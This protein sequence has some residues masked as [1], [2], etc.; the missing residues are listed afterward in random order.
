MTNGGPARERASPYA[1]A[2]WI[3]VATGVILLS[4]GRVPICTCGTIKLWH[5]AVNS[6]ENSQHLTDWYTFSHIIHGFIFYA[7]LWWLKPEWS[8]AERFLA[9]M[10][11]ESGWEILENSP[12]I[13]NRYRTA[14]ISLDYYGDSVINSLSDIAAMAAGFT[15]ASVLPVAATVA[16]ALAFEAGTAYIIRD[17]LAL[18]VLMLVHPIDAVKAWQAALPQ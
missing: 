17:N 15:L 4:M 14:T 11:V 13:I 6:S 7:V 12:L 16:I 3:A 8:F 1:I 10:L 2:I 9:A 18:N 5:G